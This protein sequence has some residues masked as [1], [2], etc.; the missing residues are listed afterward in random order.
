MAQRHINPVALEVDHLRRCLDPHFDFRVQLTEA[1]NSW[2]QP[3]GSERRHRTDGEGLFNRHGFQCRKR[4]FNLVKAAQ[5]ARV[6]ARTGF[7][8]V[9]AMAATH[10][11][12]NAYALLQQTNLLTDRTW[13]NP[14]AFSRGLQTPKAPCFSK[15]T[16]CEQR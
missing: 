3:G 15:G 8:E 7:G 13:G 2:H 9:D 11:Q 4:F 16:Q 12:R 5:Q 14:Q 6:H 1:T 10:K